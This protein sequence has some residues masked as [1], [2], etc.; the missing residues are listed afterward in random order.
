MLNLAITA[1][2]SLGKEIC[3]ELVTSPSHFTTLKTNIQDLS[4]RCSTPNQHKEQ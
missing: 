2:F 3:G 4:K 1:L